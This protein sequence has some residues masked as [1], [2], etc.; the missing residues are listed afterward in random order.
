MLEPYMKVPPLA[1]LHG[2][3]T[4]RETDAGV[5]LPKVSKYP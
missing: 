2:E 3:D 1:V 5:A 4:P